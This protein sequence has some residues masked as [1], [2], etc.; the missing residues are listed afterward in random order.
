MLGRLE[1]VQEAFPV[2]PFS[3]DA[4]GR[5]ALTTYDYDDYGRLITRTR[6]DQITTYE[7]DRQDRITRITYP[8][9]IWKRYIRN[10]RGAIVATEIGP[11]PILRCDYDYDLNGNQT[12][13]SCQG[14]PDLARVTEFTYDDYNRRT[15]E[16]RKESQP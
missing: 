4:P 14:C 1:T 2:G 3:K 12:L 13:R 10:G 8:D 9:G 5:W 11:D 16:I 15:A 6:G 7:Y